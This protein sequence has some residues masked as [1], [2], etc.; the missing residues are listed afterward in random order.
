MQWNAQRSNI[1]QAL[2]HRLLLQY[3][4][5]GTLTLRQLILCVT[6]LILTQVIPSLDDKCGNA[7]IAVG[8]VTQL[9]NVY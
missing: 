1:L 2:S 6:E 3:G 5:R 8:C 7:T 9:G 4:Q